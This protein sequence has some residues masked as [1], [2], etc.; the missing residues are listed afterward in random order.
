MKNVW[1]EKTLAGMTPGEK[2]GQVLMVAFHGLNADTL[3]GVMDKI[4]RYH[5]GGYFQC[6]NTMAVMRD[7]SEVIQ[8]EAGRPILA[9]ADLES[10]TGYMFE[11]GSLFPRQMA[12]AAGG[13]EKTEYEIGRITAREGRAVGIHM[14]AS[15][16][17]DVH[18]NPAYPDGNTRAYGDDPAVVTRLAVANI[19][20]LQENGMAAIAKH[21]PGTGSTDMDQHMAAAFIPESRARMESV[22]LRPYREA[23]R[24]TDLMS[25]MV[26]HLDVPSLVKEKHPVDGL[27]VPTSLSREIITGILK[28]KLGFRGIAMTDAFNMGGVNNRYTRAE[29]SAKA[30]QAG[31][32][33]VLCFDHGTL[34]V[35][36]EGVLKGVKD[37]VIPARR[38]D[39]AVRNILG[40]MRR[41]G[42]DSGQ[43]GPLSREEF[44]A[45][46]PADR[47]DALSRG[48]TDR[49]VTVL[50]NRP[51]LLPLANMRGK[52]ALVISAYNPDRELVVKKGH[53]PYVESVPDL[54]RKRGLSVT[55]VEVTPEFGPDDRVRMNRIIAKS[56]IVFLDI[57]GIPSYGIG[58]ILPHRAVMELFYNGI[59]NCGKPVVVNLFGDPFIS[60][61][62]PSARAL[63]CTF[64]ETVYSQESAIKVCFGEIPARGRSP[65]NLPP[66]FTRGSG[67]RI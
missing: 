36:Y 55:V 2:A 15:P 61:Y 41:L 67:E 4:K 65:V 25:V 31:V 63:L 46:I 34:E 5:L 27:P 62:A 66:W 33:I 26:S 14:T 19:R 17:L 40:I 38:L 57:F 58:T 3:P 53:K 20:G 56:D 59:L 32:D 42:L 47:H 8:R 45:A 16:V 43:A 50:R 9:G 29:A 39:D 60:R 30:I 22:F 23:I 48:I 64:D 10:G 13:D 49:A 21:F 44:A 18:V 51:R 6:K 24:R 35:E 7:V 11:G 28:K 54:L 1:V 12:R 52:K 37:G